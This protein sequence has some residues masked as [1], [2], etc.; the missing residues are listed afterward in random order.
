MLL[1]S[2]RDGTLETFDA[3]KIKRA[4][5]LAFNAVRPGA[6]PNVAPLV[7]ACMDLVRREPAGT[8]D[9]ERIHELTEIVLMD[10][11]HYAVARSY[12]IYRHMRRE[13]REP[14]KW[15]L[16]DYIQAAKYARYDTGLGRREVYSETV[17]RGRDMHIR[18]WPEHE[19][20]LTRAYALV[21]EKKVLPSMRSMQFGGAAIE[22]HHGRMYNCS[23]TLMDRWR[24]FSDAFFL[25]L[26]GC[27]VGYSVQWE[28]VDQLPAVGTV[29]RDVYHHTVEDTIEG[30]GRA[31]EALFTSF[32]AGLWIEFDY[33][34]VRSEGA[35]L[36]T[37]GGRAPGHLPLRGVLEA[38]RSRLSAA[39]GRRLRPIEVN[40]IMCLLAE[41]VLSGGIRRSALICLFSATDTEMIY[42]K[43]NENYRPA[44][45]SDPGH[46]P[47][48]AMANNSGVLLRAE[49]R[50]SD[51]RRLISVA[52]GNNGCPGF[53]F[54]NDIN[55]G[56][57]PCG[58]IGLDPRLYSKDRD[59]Y[60][61][62]FAFCNLT[63]INAA[64]VTSR[65]DFLSRC[66]AAAT[67]GT[68]QAAYTRFDYL[69]SVTKAIAERDGLLGVSLTGIQ[70]NRDMILDASLLEAGVA[71]IKA[72]NERLAAQLGLAAGARL[73]TVKPSGTASIVLGCVGPGIHSNWAPRYIRRVNANPNEPVAR[74]FRRVNPHMVQE[75]PDGS[76]SLMFPVVG[77]GQTV[78]DT[79]AIGFVDDVL[80][81]YRHWVLPGSIRGGLTHNVSCTVTVRDGELEEVLQMVWRQ[82][83]AVAAMAFGGYYL[84]SVFPFVPMK[85]ITSV[86]DES[87]WDM[88]IAGYTPVDW[89]AFIEDG[90][91][92]VLRDVQA[93]AGAAGCG[94]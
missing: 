76:W 9:V 20:E 25:L 2:K 81:V 63:E 57:N 53:L 29:G 17:A 18:R 30:W 31:C 92:T 12:V 58:E 41:A 38:V 52:Q 4:L 36:V 14:D 91:S 11:G 86:E 80:F 87:V 56:T 79:Q 43:S 3:E 46:N 24:A 44:F 6:I 1:V 10:A 68:F 88:L 45:G 74:E 84:D 66:D 94:V 64:T 50:E 8:V 82:R 54:V 78:K 16:P 22:A 33:S 42:A 69:G 62:G 32:E 71:R 35:L 75:K 15:A 47:H 48:R 37:S 5:L 61:T 34:G 77:E 72:V 67:I 51:F 26:C 89:A 13:A 90:D 7:M 23:F 83:A 49:A 55:H 28:H 60:E 70:D 65:E 59:S 39:Q 93:C 85:A 40:D 27:G 21:E 73:T 19:G